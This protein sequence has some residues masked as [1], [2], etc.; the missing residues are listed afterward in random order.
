MSIYALIFLRTF[1]KF[2]CY[3]FEFNTFWDCRPNRQC[4]EWYFSIL[5]SSN[6]S[7]NIIYFSK[8][9]L[10]R[11]T[12]RWF[13]TNRKHVWYQ[14]LLC[15]WIFQ[16]IVRSAFECKYIELIYIFFALNIVKRGF[17][18]AVLDLLFYVL[19]IILNKCVW[20]HQS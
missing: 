7:S 16:H 12:V 1:L 2:A 8:Y 5:I 4:T 15:I 19:G 17:N 6:M 3:K 13:L 20:V 10:W 14:S 9:V 18:S 11:L